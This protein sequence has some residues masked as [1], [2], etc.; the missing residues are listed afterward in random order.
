MSGQAAFP[1]HITEEILLEIF[2]RLPAKSLGKCMCVSKAWNFLIK[3]P[4]FISSHARHHSKLRCRNNNKNLFF[5]M[6]AR[7]Q[8]EYSLH[9]DDQDFSKYTQLEYMPFDNHHFVVGSCNGLLCLIDFQFGFDIVFTLCNP[10]IKKSITLPK[11]C[12]RHL[13]Y[14]I[15]VGFGFDSVKNDYKLLKITKE[16]VLDKFVEVELYS[17]NRNSWRTLAPLRYGLYSDDFMVFVNGIV[18]WIAYERVEDQG[19]YRCKFLIMGFDMKDDVFK[20]IMLPGNL[21]N[22]PNQSEIYVIPY[23]ELSSIAVIEL[24]C[25]HTQ[26]NIW[27]MKKYGVVETWTKMFSIGNPGPEPMPRVLGFVKNGDLI[28]GAYN[29]L[30]LVSLDPERSELGYFGIQGTRSYVSTFMECLVL[31]DQ[32][33]GDDMTENDVKSASNAKH[34]IESAADG[35]TK[36]A[37]NGETTNDSSDVEGWRSNELF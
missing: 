26:C 9:F 24:G 5:V 7:H 27:V 3:N 20:E 11:P 28:L 13:P 23:E 31:L 30:Q 8:V 2:N 12:L 22:L 35:F 19:V 25:L 4:F 16:N 21:R 14:K 17:F 10:I 1:G 34:S 33:N 15:S 18:H 37:T 36:L 6:T 29:N 32:V